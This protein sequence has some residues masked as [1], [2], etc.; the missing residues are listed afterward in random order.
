MSYK[1]DALYLLKEDVI[2]LEAKGCIQFSYKMPEV[3]SEPSCC[4]FTLQDQCSFLP[5]A[6]DVLGNFYLYGLISI[7]EKG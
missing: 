2:G 1:W 7:I 3:S 4:A 6:G 5:S